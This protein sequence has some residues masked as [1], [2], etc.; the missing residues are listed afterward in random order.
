MKKSLSL[1]L[2]LGYSFIQILNQV[3]K[4]LTRDL[5]KFISELDLT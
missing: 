2:I 5:D 1:L 4:F 3:S